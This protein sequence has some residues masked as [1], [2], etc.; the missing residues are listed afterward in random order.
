MQPLYDL[1][2]LKKPTNV[3]INA[4]LLKKAKAL[5]INFSSALEQ[6]LV[7]LIKEKQIAEW[8]SSNQAAIA[9]YNRHIEEKGLFA[10]GLRSF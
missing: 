9:H 2:A 10:D 1:S 7:D 8:L 3:S 4:D 6:K 5:D